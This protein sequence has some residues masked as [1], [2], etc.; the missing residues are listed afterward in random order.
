MAA[1]LRARLDC[2]PPSLK[3]SL[4]PCRLTTRTPPLAMTILAAQAALTPTNGSRLPSSKPS[5]SACGIRL[6]LRSCSYCGHR[7]RAS[8]SSS[9][10][11]AT[12]ILFMG[13]VRCLAA[14]AA[15]LAAAAA[16]AACDAVGRAGHFPR[17][18]ACLAKPLAAARAS[19]GMCL[20]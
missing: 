10:T 15:G 8:P 12:S 4:T 9:A 6:W 1:V 20:R 16:R 3:T 2:R 14:A 11:T 19:T 17:R 7:W 18:S 5:R 13:N